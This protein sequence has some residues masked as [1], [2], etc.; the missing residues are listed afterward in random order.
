MWRGILG[1]EVRKVVE[2]ELKLERERG[3]VGRR[4]S[5]TKL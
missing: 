1:R 4:K 2:L 3:L 5:D